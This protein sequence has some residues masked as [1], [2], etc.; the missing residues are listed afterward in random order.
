[1]PRRRPC[2]ASAAR[3]TYDEA[4]LAAWAARLE[5]FLAAG[6][7]AF[8]FFAHDAVGH[9]AELGLAFSRLLEARLPGS[10]RPDRT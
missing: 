6:D 5:P 9:G 1:M 8:V 3:C 2:G 10:T 4:A 7:E